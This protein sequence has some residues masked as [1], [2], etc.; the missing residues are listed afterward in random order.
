MSLIRFHCISGDVHGLSLNFKRFSMV[1]NGFLQAHW[2][3][4]NFVSFFFV[5][6]KFQ[7]VFIV[8]QWFLTDFL[9]YS[10]HV[11][12]LCRFL[13]LLHNYLLVFGNLSSCSRLFLHDYP[14]ILESFF[15]FCTFRTVLCRTITNLWHFLFELFKIVFGQRTFFFVRIIV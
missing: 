13:F 1:F 9:W 6:I 2:F 8:V 11:H 14:Q 15:M 7:Q 5:L 10:L 4:L 3:S 12:S